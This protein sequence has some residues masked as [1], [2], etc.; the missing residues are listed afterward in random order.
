MKQPTRFSINRPLSSILK[1]GL[2][3][4]AVVLAA[5]GGSDG[6]GIGAASGGIAKASPIAPVEQAAYVQQVEAFTPAVRPTGEDGRLRTLGFGVRPR[7]AQ[8]MLPPWVAVPGSSAKSAP[9]GSADGAVS[10]ASPGA[11]AAIPVQVGA[12]RAVAETVSA[13]GTAR[14]LQWN[15]AS[16]PAAAISFTS[17]GAAGLRIGLLVRHLPA[18]AVVRGYAQGAA[19]AFEIPASDI[20]ATVA[21][22]RDAGDIS[23]AGRTFWTP[24]IDGPE[25]TLEITLPAGASP[26]DLDVAVPT[27]SHLTVPVGELLTTKIGEAASCEVDISC[28][29]GNDA[30]SRSV[31]R[32]I[33]S[34]A[35]NTYACTGTLLNDSV[36]SATP[37]LLSANHCISSQTAASTLNTYWFYRST[38]CNSGVLNPNYSRLAGGA[39]LLYASGA[40]D[41]SFMRL[42]EAAPA[43]ATFAGWSVNPPDSAPDVIAIHH[44]LADLQKFA[45]GHFI[46]YTNCTGPAGATFSCST[47]NAGN[48]GFFNTVLTTGTTEGGSSGSAAFAAIGGGRYVVGQLYGGDASCKKPSGSNIYG[49]L[50]Q[51]Y[52]SGLARWLSPAPPLS[53]GSTARSAVYRFYN[54][55]TGAH[56]FTQ[57]GAERD[58]VITSLPSFSYEGVAFYAYS[59]AVAGTSPVY[60]FYNTSNGRHFYTINAAERDYVMANYR[61]YSF[62]G[63]SWFAQAQEGGTASPVYRFYNAP[64]DTHFYTISGAEK[65][66]VLQNYPSYT[67]EGI[68]YFAWTTQ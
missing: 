65:D 59:T 48:S 49:R 20:L 25:A 6:D 14:L 52:R 51:A 15:G 63:S 50:D 11:A 3:A 67:F 44:P 47:G 37:Y 1:A 31:A 35:G 10:A 66:A 45:Q 58:Y 68:G 54:A 40:T 26:A 30:L 28:T 56:F 41:T 2:L 34:D 60:R 18:D 43:N 13:A 23:D 21:R 29:S 19:T 57:N 16:A 9:A 42:N 8:V 64:N 53:P 62:E 12:G 5:C 38:S 32:M 39:T 61:Q 4:A 55:S 33:F 27:V 46:S 24:V 17:P 36:S 22:N 7:A